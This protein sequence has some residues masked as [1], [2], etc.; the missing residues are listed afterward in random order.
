MSRIARSP[1]TGLVFL[2]LAVA[3]AVLVLGQ[4]GARTAAAPPPQPH[5]KCY[6]IPPGPTPVP[7]VTLQT[8]F[9]TEEIPVGV[10]AK[11]CLPAGKNAEP[12]PGPEWPHL[13]CYN[14]VGQNPPDV[15]NLETQFGVENYVVVRHASLLCVPAAKTIV[16]APPG[17]EP[18]PTL[19]YECYDIRGSDP[20]DVVALRTQFGLE[21][22]VAVGQATKLCVPALKNGGG[23]LG[24]PDLKCYTITGSPPGPV[25]NLTTQFGVE[26]GI[27]VGGPSLLCVPADKQLVTP[28]PMPTAVGGIAELPD[29]A[30]ASA[31]EAGAP[32]GGSGWS[33]A[34]Y[35][36]L[37]G[38]L[39]AA[40]VF[41]AGAWYYARRRWIR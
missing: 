33:T 7:T 9:G 16:P 12:T 20:P 41:G 18:P 37:A 1:L 25:V 11:L 6:D 26:A 13:E 28:T 10:P 19:H 27:P 35:A 34:G 5:Y 14:I 29:I 22:G 4:G 8:Q 40:V 39:A 17:S 24:A 32:A 3:L 23:N 38:G 15:V 31:E 21:S 36:G 30:G 2:V